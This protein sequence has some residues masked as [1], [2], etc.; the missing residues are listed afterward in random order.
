MKKA[1]KEI[2]I[3]GRMVL[4]IVSILTAI[5]LSGYSMLAFLQGTFTANHAVLLLLAMSLL[6]LSLIV[7]SK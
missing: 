1:Q 7:Q 6:S 5:V 2:V 3:T 4:R